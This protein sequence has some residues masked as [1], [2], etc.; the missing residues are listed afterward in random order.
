MDWCCFCKEK[1]W[2]VKWKVTIYFISRNLVVTLDSI[3]T[4]CIKH[5]IST[6]YISAQKYFWLIYWTVN[7]AF[8][9][10][11]NYYIWFFFFKY[12]IYS[13]PVCDICF[14]EFKVWLVHN[15]CQC[16]HIACICEFVNTQYHIF[17]IF[18]C[19]IM[20]E[21]PPNKSS[22]AGYNYIHNIYHFPDNTIF[23]ETGTVFD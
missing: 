1:V 17:W 13:I 10:K 8:S 16:L 2:P 6:N 5:N 19:H 11:I 9:S 3:F 20:T 14:K 15:R 23:W 22:S 18:F 21:V 7:M 12:L 4:A